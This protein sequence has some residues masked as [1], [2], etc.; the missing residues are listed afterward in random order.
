M[1]EEKFEASVKKAV[2]VAVASTAAGLGSQP[3]GSLP[4]YVLKG[5]RLVRKIRRNMLVDPRASA[6]AARSRQLREANHDG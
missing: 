2:V 6:L 1:S 3:P 5:N 4:R